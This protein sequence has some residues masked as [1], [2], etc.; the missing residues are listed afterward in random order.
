MGEEMLLVCGYKFHVQKLVN[1]E[2][3]VYKIVEY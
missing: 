1:V 2:Y 3:N